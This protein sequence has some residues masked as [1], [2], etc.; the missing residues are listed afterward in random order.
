MEGVLTHRWRARHHIRTATIV[1]QLQPA[2]GCLNHL[3][4]LRTFQYCASQNWYHLRDRL[5]TR[6]GRE[7]LSV[8]FDLK[9]ASVRECDPDCQLLWSTPLFSGGSQHW[10]NWSRVW[11]LLLFHWFLPKFD[12][13]I[14]QFVAGQMWASD[15]YVCV[16]PESKGISL[17]QQNTETAF[18]GIYQQSESNLV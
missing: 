1:L 12:Y 17:S 4:P 16:L 2:A 14:K 5:L 11:V 9:S 7:N 15:S 18:E 10:T 3:V 13:T 8:R 6:Q